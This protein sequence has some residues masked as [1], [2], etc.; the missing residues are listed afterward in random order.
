MNRR[1]FLR[2]SIAAGVVA[3]V[4]FVA[5]SKA[6]PMRITG[7]GAYTRWSFDGV[8]YTLYQGPYHE[9]N[10]AGYLLESS[11]KRPPPPAN[12]A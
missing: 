9:G 5:D 6:E 11:A 12:K 2:C 4:P 8:E 3:A 1:D 10:F 7:F